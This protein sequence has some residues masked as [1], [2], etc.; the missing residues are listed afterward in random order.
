VL[1]AGYNIV[2]IIREVAKR[3]VI[4]DDLVDNAIKGYELLNFSFLHEDMLVVEK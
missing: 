1:L 3:S 4:D 2:Y